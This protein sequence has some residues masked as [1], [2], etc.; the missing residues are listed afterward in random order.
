MAIGMG[1]QVVILDRSVDALRRLVSE[2]GTAIQTVYSSKAALN[3]HVLTA[4][5]VIGGVLIP[6]AAAPKL[7]TADMVSRM[8]PGSAI[9]DV[10]IDQGGCFETSHATTHQDPTYI[11]DDVVHYCVAN[12]PGAVARTSTLSLNNATLPYIVSLADLGWEEAIQRDEHLANGLNVHAGKITSEEVAV[13]LGR[14][15][16]PYNP[17][18][19]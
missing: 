19:A 17:T 5:L 12:M 10:A 7:V 2:F 4:D 8:K 16:T 1:A 6:G 15:F 14:E 18:N 9:V 3:E 11:V 13:A